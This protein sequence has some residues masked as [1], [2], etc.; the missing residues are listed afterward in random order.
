MKRCVK[1][2]LIQNLQ[3]K[4]LLHS[5][6]SRILITLFAVLHAAVAK[7]TYGILDIGCSTRTTTVVSM[8]E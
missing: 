2:N 8:K 7:Q 1:G 3:A 6:S 4:M 5:I